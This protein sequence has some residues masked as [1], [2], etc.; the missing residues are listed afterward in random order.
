MKGRKTNEITRTSASGSNSD[1]DFGK[2]KR[3]IVRRDHEV[4]VKKHF[5]SATI[6][7]ADNRGNE[8][9]ARHCSLRNG[10]ES[11]GRSR[12]PFWTVPAWLSVGVRG[13]LLPAVSIKKQCC[14]SSKV[15]VV[16][17]RERVR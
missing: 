9:F 3:C 8:R 1:L 13:V 4:T 12:D 2:C 5:Y 11:M 10:A 15:E 14:S 16:R 7:A 17:V 6:G